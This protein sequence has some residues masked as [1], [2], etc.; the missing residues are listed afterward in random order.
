MEKEKQGILASWHQTKQFG[1]VV[2]R[3]GSKIERY[4]L[5][6]MRVDMCEPQDPY[7]GCTVKFNVSG[8]PPKKVSDLPF[9]IDAEVYMPGVRS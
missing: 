2:C 7:I 8:I 9:A 5:T 6:L 3:N 1:Y 4:F